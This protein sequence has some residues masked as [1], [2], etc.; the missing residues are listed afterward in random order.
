MYSLFL[1]IHYIG[2]SLNPNSTLLPLSHL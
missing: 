2:C 1:F